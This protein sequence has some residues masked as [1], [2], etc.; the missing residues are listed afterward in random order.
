MTESLNEM[1]SFFDSL[2]LDWNQRRESNE[3]IKTLLPHFP[4]KEGAE[5]LD[6]ACGAGILEEYLFSLSH[7]KIT[8]IDLSLGMIN[9]AKKNVSSEIASFSQ[10]DFLT[11][12]GGPFDVIVLFDAFPHFL[13]VKALKE[14]FL[15]N[16]KSG[17]Y[18]IIAHD[19]SR[20]GLSKCHEGLGNSLSREIKDP[21]SEF[22][23]F[24][25][26][27]LQIEAKEDERSYLLIGMKIH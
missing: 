19:L 18:F 2:S 12:K 26:D 14:A 3:G 20:E 8:S 24:A 27:F 23:A 4:I 7:K 16:L 13:D 15:T 9:E 21:Q 22:L 6:V 1:A 17:G 10:S 11:Y 5:V 25:S